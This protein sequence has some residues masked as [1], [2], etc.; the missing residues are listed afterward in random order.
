[1]A[2][3]RLAS[4]IYPT[5]ATTEETTCRLIRE[6]EEEEGVGEGGT[7]GGRGEVVGVAVTVT[8]F[9]Q[10]RSLQAPS[11]TQN[12]NHRSQPQMAMVQTVRPVAARCKTLVSEKPLVSVSPLVSEMPLINERSLVNVRP[13]VTVKDLVKAKPLVNVSISETVCVQPVIVS[14]LND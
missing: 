2:A 1:M 6:E 8:M 7:R 14:A 4:W 13:L 5:L 3:L 9:P 10:Q 12:K 11:K